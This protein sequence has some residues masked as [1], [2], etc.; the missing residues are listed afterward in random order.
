[1]TD[2][3]AQPK[4]TLSTSVKELPGVGKARAASLN[5]LG[6]ENVSD[7]LRHLPMRYEFLAGETSVEQLQADTIGTAR[8][9]VA[10][11]RWVAG[12]RGK[13][14]LEV[15]LQDEADTLRLVWFN[16]AYL[17]EK[18]FPGVHLRVTGKVQHFGGYPQMVN[19]KFETLAYD[20]VPEPLPSYRRPIYPATEK[21]PS[22][23][24]EELIAHCLDQLAGQIPDPLPVELLEHHAM[25]NLA[26]ALMLVHR[27]DQP[28]DPGVG[29]RRLAFNELLL[30][31]LGIELKRQYNQ[32]RLQ[33]PTLRFSQAKDEH[34]RQRFGFELTDSQKQV[35]GEIAKDLQ[36]DVPMNRL[37]Q[38]DVGSGKTVI[39]LYG[40]LMA[41]SDGYQGAL[42]AP[43]E[44]L[45]EQ[46]YL[47]MSKMLKG[48]S[49][50]IELLTAGQA[51]AN[52]VA[53][54]EI[55]A[56]IE[57]GEIDIIIGT[58]ALVSE[59]IKFSN[60]ALVVVDEQ[61][62]F[63]VLQRAAFRSKMSEQVQ[64]GR[65]ASP[66]YLV[67][68][69][70][71]IPRTLSLT[72][73]GDLDVS[74]IHGLP[75]GRKPIITR[76]VGSEKSDDVY[77]YIASRVAKGEQVYVVVPAIDESEEESENQLK[78]VAAHSRLLQEKYFADFTV[79]S[80]HGRL[81][82]A[83]RDV[84]MGSFREGNV[85]VLVAT[86]VIEV[87]VD[88]PNATMIVI[89]HAERFGLAQLHQLRGR[90]GRGTKDVKN[91]CVLIADPVT[92]EGQQR[93]DAI[94]DSTD[95]FRIAEKDLEIRGMGDFFG[96]RQHGMP[97]LRVARIPEDMDLLQLAK[98]D[99][100]DM[101]K[102]DAQL[103]LPENQTLRKVL[104]KQYGTALGLIDVG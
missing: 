29:R 30:L 8:G 86:T 85:H 99:A 3:K 27:P 79:S 92:D 52:S 18:L 71:P 50:R 40:L 38:G 77:T 96:T 101:V 69:A 94:A 70:T 39:A 48:S 35:V 32:D 100:T 88:V 22:S 14:R 102:A 59:S 90:I 75:P 56:R 104:L 6:I 25:P 37:V 16:A 11:K 80:M 87:G 28:D 57:A 47:S 36:R 23:Q 31:Q 34:I 9:I 98:R 76:V 42:M 63:G 2:P 26:E 60:L 89:E 103:K 74:T 67:M 58:Q 53:R 43:T 33:A 82:P 65:I 93:V 5:K 95:G 64:A 54:K 21:L 17:Q 97:P 72:L 78:S 55:E 83:E 4:L 10:A 66:H 12:G 44:L 20:V 1:M 46:H 61:H 15:T 24:I 84:I 41:V 73:F 62:R 51:S 91:L 81:K 19:P 49:V 13:G 45:A 68:T 7:L